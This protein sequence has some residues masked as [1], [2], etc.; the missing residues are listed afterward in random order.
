MA[1]ANVAPTLTNYLL[2]PLATFVLSVVSLLL[3][4]NSELVVLFLFLLMT[5]WIISQVFRML[6]R[7]FSN[8]S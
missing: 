8:D 5:I 7:C 1:F 3:T 2:K 6:D 4:R